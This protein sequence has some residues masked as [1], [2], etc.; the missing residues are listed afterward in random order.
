MILIY[1]GTD[2]ML[3]GLLQT[4]FLNP[5]TAGGKYPLVLDA[6]LMSDRQ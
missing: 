6:Q 4:C 1:H 5:R 2:V 3:H